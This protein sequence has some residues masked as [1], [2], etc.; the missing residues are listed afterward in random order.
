[1]FLHELGVGVVSLHGYNMWFHNLN[2]FMKVS[3]A[4]KYILHSSIT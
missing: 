3:Q 4:N 2:V 1:M